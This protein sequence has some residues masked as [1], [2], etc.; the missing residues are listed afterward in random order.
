MEVGNPRLGLVAPSPTGTRSPRVG[1]RYGQSSSFAFVPDF[2]MR[3]SPACVWKEEARAPWM[4]SFEGAQRVSKC[5]ALGHP[6]HRN[7]CESARVAVRCGRVV[8]PK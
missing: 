6:F 3:T 4:A 5:A 8:Q 7:M 1:E 2:S